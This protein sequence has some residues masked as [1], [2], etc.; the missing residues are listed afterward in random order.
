M[1]VRDETMPVLVTVYCDECGVTVTN[2]YLVPKNQ[3]SLAV[4]RKYLESNEGWQVSAWDDLCPEC[5]VP[6]EAV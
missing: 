3:D 6:A 5:K 4:A 1:A 2:D